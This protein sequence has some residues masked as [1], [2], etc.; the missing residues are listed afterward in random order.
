MEAPTWVG[1]VKL[2]SGLSALVGL[3]EILA[4]IALGYT[5]LA[6]PAINAVVVGFLVVT[7]S[8]IQW[9]GV[10]RASWTGWLIAALGIWL[11]LAPFV[12][13]YFLLPKPTPNDVGIGIIVAALGTWGALAILWAPPR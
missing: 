12:L 8:L 4:P 11:V 6:T 5:S 9:F 13:G 7:L 10:S 3:W 2:V 1:Q